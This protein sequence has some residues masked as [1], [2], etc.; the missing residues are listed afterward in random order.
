M[1]DKYKVV[2]PYTGA[3]SALKRGGA[4]MLTA[5]WTD[6]EN[7]VLIERSRHRTHRA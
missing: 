1:M 5:R 6:P 4:L 7:T 3:H 2:L